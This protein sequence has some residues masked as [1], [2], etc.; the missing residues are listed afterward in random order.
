MDTVITRASVFLPILKLVIKT[1]KLH[2]RFFNFDLRF[3]F[4]PAFKVIIGSVI[5]NKNLWPFEPVRVKYFGSG[6]AVKL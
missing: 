4:Q 6:K 3:D 1:D 2:E 5:C